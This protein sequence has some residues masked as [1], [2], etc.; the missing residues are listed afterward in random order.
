MLELI[1]Q[2]FIPV[3]KLPNPEYDGFMCWIF[4]DTDEFHKVFEEL[5]GKKAG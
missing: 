3:G 4:D 1:K 2:G 5:T